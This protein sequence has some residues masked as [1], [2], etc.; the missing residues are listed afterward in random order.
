MEW[1]K[2]SASIMEFIFIFEETV[3]LHLRIKYG[4]FIRLHNIKG[5]SRAKDKTMYVNHEMHLKIISFLL[6]LHTRKK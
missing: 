4:Y 1:I 6:S 3:V 2:Y 5:V